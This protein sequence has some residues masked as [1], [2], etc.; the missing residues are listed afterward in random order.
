MKKSDNKFIYLNFVSVLLRYGLMVCLCLFTACA[1]KELRLSGERENVLSGQRKLVIDS[2]AAAE[3]AGL[4]EI[5]LNSAF[6]HPGVSSA[7]DGGIC[8]STCP[9]TLEGSY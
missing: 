7:H 6:G 5:V 8:L 1:D 3:V 9:K 2:Q 4:G